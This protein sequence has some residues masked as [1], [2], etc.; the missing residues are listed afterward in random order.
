MC[1]SFI[2]SFIQP[3]RPWPLPK[4]VLHTV[5][6]SASSLNFQYASVS[7][8]SSSSCLRLLPRF[9]ITSILPSIFPSITCF[10]RQFLRKMWSIQLAFLHLLV[11]RTFVSSTLCT[12]SSF[13]TRSVQPIFSILFQHHTKL[14]C[15]CSTSLVFFL[16]YKPNF[17]GESLPEC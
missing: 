6:Y 17:F 4:C 1:S 13:F 7:I 16:K 15:V 9:T 14:C 10:R 11:C 5:R 3:V 8:R 2:H 12:T